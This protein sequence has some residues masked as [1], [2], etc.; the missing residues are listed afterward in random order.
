MTG[1]RYVLDTPESTKTFLEQLKRDF[2]VEGRFSGCKET[3]SVEVKAK[4][5]K[6]YDYFVDLEFASEEDARLFYDNKDK[7]INLIILP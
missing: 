2:K 6:T 1:L 3:E 5:F 7:V 4:I